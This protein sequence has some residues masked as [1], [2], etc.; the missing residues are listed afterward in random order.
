[1][2]NKAAYDSKYRK[3]LK[4]LAPKQMFQSLPI[5]QVQINK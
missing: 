4:L 2:V 3:G 1:M 5:A